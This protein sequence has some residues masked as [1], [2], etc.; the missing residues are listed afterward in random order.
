MIGH[1]T[2]LER[3]EE[4]GFLVVYRAHDP[5][6]NRFVAVK[7]C[8][9][10]DPVL[11][12]LFLDRAKS[13]SRLHH[14]SIA[15]VFEL[16]STEDRPYLVQEHP[17]GETLESRLEQRRPL[18]T[19]RRLEILLEIAQALEHAHSEEVLHRDLR[20]GAIRLLENGR[21]QV[22]DFGVARLVSTAG[23]L[24]RRGT[25]PEGAGYPAPEQ[26]AGWGSD[27]RSDVFSFGALAYHLLTGQRPFAG[28]T[29]PQL[30][31]STLLTE[32]KPA[33]SLWPEC[34]PELEHLLARCLRKE[35]RERY[36]SFV[37]L[38]ADLTPLAIPPR[39]LEASLD[40]TQ[41]IPTLRPGRGAPA[42]G[43]RRRRSTE[44]DL[45]TAYVMEPPPTAAP[46]PAPAP[47][48]ATPGRP[49]SSPAR[50]SPRRVSVLSRLA[51]AGTAVG[52]TLGAGRAMLGRWARAAG[53]RWR[54]PKPRRA[55]RAHAG[56]ARRGGRARRRSVAAPVALALLLG[57][58]GVGWL[59]WTLAHHSGSPS[60]P[61]P[62]PSEP[63][64]TAAT[65]DVDG[66]LVVDASPWAEV[67]GLTDGDG[68]RVPLPKNRFTPLRLHLPAG[69]YRVEL[70]RPGSE[71]R[72]CR[73]E[74]T[75]AGTARC[76]AELEQ[77]QALD[78]F[79]ESGW[80]R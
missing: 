53:S 69:S 32:P 50:R 55:P 70:Q 68:H 3:I 8:V 74:V 36:V 35:P 75:A 34:V 71:P 38:L 77:L 37:D 19:A 27:E 73:A 43:K 2:I 12:E 33:S 52:G 80:W 24:A 31:E 13:A 29:L 65:P 18:E 54:T 66:F 76:R 61:G 79:K 14:P 46:T 1:Y 64:A 67:V 7:V 16:G 25:L 51:A 78:Y 5:G 21:V 4:D 58:A 63:V 40:D 10:G 45:K 9:T 47:V 22:T 48:P 11:R 30:V 62:P 57:A 41:P 26:L 23:T 72:T 60:T 44:E 28:T 39:D 17:P 59:G 49:P 15:T 20:P 6:R 42:T 56:G